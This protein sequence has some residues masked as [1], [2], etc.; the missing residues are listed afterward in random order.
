MIIPW[1]IKHFSYVCVQGRKEVEEISHPSLPSQ[2]IQEKQQLGLSCPHQTSLF[3]WQGIFSIENG[4]LMYVHLL[5]CYH[6]SSAFP[7]P[8]FLVIVTQWHTQAL[9]LHFAGQTRK[10]VQVSSS[11]LWLSRFSAVLIPVILQVYFPWTQC[12]Q[13][14]QI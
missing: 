11:T 2:L 7:L 4:Y 5:F 10:V 12:D 14:Y 9:N 13:N 8:S 6:G 3:W 1:G